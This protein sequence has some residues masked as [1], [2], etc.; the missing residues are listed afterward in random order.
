M[1]H[2]FDTQIRTAPDGSA[3]L[4]VKGELDLASAARFREAVGALMAAGTRTVVVDLSG[5][6]FVDSSGIGAVLWAEHRLRATGGDLITTGST[7]PVTRAFELAGLA[8]MVH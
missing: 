3:V 7:P 1:L 4:A 6:D 8:S 5:S 2:T